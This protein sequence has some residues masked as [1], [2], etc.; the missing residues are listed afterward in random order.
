MSLGCVVRVH[1]GAQYS[2]VE[3][4]SE[5]DAILSISTPAPSLALVN[6]V[7]HLFFVL[8]FFI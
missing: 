4:T 2:P 3:Y 1:T 5:S 6:F 8:S 7:K